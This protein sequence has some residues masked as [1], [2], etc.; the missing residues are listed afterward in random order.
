M[1]VRT[2][3]VVDDNPADLDLCRL[4]F[5]PTGHYEKIVTVNTAEKALA[6]LS[7]GPDQLQPDVILLDI[8]MPGMDGFEFIEAYKVLRSR[9]HD[10][11]VVVMLSSSTDPRDHARARESGIVRHF[12]TK[13]PSE[14]DAQQI[15]ELFGS[16][17][18]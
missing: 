11:A 7:T 5:E 12:V 13:P 16:E 8:N 9:T 4:I 17:R 18:G 3:L 1:I 2:L 14:H 10:T 6:L 15:A